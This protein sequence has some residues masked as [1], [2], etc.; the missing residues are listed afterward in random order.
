M[1]KIKFL[2]TKLIGDYFVRGYVFND[3][4]Y[5]QKQSIHSTRWRFIDSSSKLWAAFFSGKSKTQ[6]SPK[7][8]H[9]SPEKV[10]KI[11]RLGREGYPP[12]II[13]DLLKISIPTIRKILSYQTH[14]NMA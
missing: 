9:L 5:V 14:T 2:H 8:K 10:N 13:K 3:V 7:D 4:L 12:K 1:Q 11:R 6:K